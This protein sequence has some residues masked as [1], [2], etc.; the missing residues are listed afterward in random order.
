MHWMVPNPLFQHWM[1]GGGGGGALDA[2]ATPTMK[3]PKKYRNA[4]IKNHLKYL[5]DLWCVLIAVSPILGLLKN[6]MPTS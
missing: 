3:C 6:R 4:T 1:I 5:S 2:C